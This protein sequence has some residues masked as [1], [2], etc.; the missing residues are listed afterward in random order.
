MNK[1]TINRSYSFINYAFQKIL[2]ELYSKIPTFYFLRQIITIQT[3]V[4]GILKT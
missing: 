3:V 1:D 2:L 4:G